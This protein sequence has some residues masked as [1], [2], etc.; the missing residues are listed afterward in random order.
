MRFIY[1]PKALTQ[2]Q[3]TCSVRHEPSI[4]AD[5]T[6]P[7]TKAGSQK[8]LADLRRLVVDV[9]R[10]NG[11]HWSSGFHE[12]KDQEKKTEVEQTRW[13]TGITTIDAALPKMGMNTATVH[14]I[15]CKSYGETAAASSYVLALLSRLAKLP[16]IK[17][18]ASILWCQ[19]ARA[20]QEFGTVQGRALRN[21]GFNVEQFVFAES[22]RKE[23]I[24]WAIEE[25]ARNTNLIA[26]IAEVDPLSFATSRR[27]ALAA[28]TGGTPILLLHQRDDNSASI[29][30]TRW[31]ISS[32]PSAKAPLAPEA[33]GHPRWHV[34]LTRCR[35]GQQGAWSMEWNCETHCF[36][37]VQE[38][39]PR[40][41]RVAYT[42]NR[43]P[44]AQHTAEPHSTS[45]YAPA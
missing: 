24:L 38:F 22:T 2:T 45:Q 34:E 15:S 32:K 27:L 8:T 25:G 1:S 7:D 43:T 36:S 9:E 12:S 6:V 16:H 42:A 37:L 33:P 28:E 35:S 39:P 17:A 14:E 41:P 23:D 18:D 21:F 11:T 30:E 13:S 3:G 4:A 19:A 26:V 20:Q 29:A 44:L 5:T 40:L 31:K 10:R